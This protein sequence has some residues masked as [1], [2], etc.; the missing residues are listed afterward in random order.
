MKPNRIIKVFEVYLRSSGTSVISK[1]GPTMPGINLIVFLPA[2]KHFKQITQNVDLTRKERAHLP[3]KARCKRGMELFHRKSKTQNR[4]V[5]Y[6]ESKMFLKG[7]EFK[8][9]NRNQESTR[10]IKVIRIIDSP[11]HFHI[12]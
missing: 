2:E 4:H 7:L 12:S 6:S 10:Q 3:Y 1:N 8:G 5:A 11:R 9:F